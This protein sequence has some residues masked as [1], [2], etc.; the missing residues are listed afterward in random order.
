MVGRRICMGVP[1]LLLALLALSAT[2]LAGA[3]YPE[4]IAAAVNL[5]PGAQVL[6]M[7]K[8]ADGVQAVLTSTDAP[9]KIIAHYKSA[10]P[11]NGWNVEQGMTAGGLDGLRSPRR[12]PAHRLGHG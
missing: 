3:K 4:E 1:A 11:G 10:L 2:A 6:A 8:D 5:C 7:Q 12:K 9:D